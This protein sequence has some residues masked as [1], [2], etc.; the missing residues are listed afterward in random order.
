MKSEPVIG[1]SRT[2]DQLH[3]CSYLDY[4]QEGRKPFIANN[5]HCNQRMRLRPLSGFRSEEKVSFK[6]RPGLLCVK[7]F[8]TDID[9][10]R[11]REWHNAIIAN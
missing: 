6:L 10:I 7:C 5:A 4:E 11:A 3:L 1:R 8:G 9:R 2:G